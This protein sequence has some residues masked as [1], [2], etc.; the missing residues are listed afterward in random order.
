[1]SIHDVN[2]EFAKVVFPK[3]IEEDK[4]YLLFTFE[5]RDPEDTDQ[6]VEVQLRSGGALFRDDAGELDM[7]LIAHYVKGALEVISNEYE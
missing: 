2:K 6:G 1:M 7:D 4:N 5:E 3:F